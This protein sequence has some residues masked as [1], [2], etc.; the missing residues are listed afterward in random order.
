MGI[1]GLLVGHVA[2]YDLVFPLDAHVHAA[3][4]AGSGHT[5]LGMLQPTLALALGFVV[6]GGWLAARTRGPRDVRYHRLLLIQLPVAFVAV[7][8]G[9]RT[10]AGYTPL[11]LWH[12]LADHGLWLI[13]VVGIVAQVITARPARLPAR[14]SLPRPHQSLPPDRVAHAG[15][16]SSP[17]VFAPTARRP[18]PATT[19][20]P[21]TAELM[22]IR[23]SM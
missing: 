21:G 8:L 4:L 15:R 7:E 12:A 18:P 13:L 23:A 11:D 3:A 20:G 5:W 9:E 10:L 6:V 2:A 14:A 1:I 17:S 19:P 22:A 16:R